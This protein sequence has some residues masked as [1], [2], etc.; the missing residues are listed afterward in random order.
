MRG[1][2]ASL[3]S[4]NLASL[5]GIS[6]RRRRDVFRRVRMKVRTL[7][8]RIAHDRK[9]RQ[10]DRCGVVLAAFKDGTAR[11]RRGIGSADTAIGVCQ[12]TLMR[13]GFGRNA[14]NGNATASSS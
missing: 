5:I 14:A 9:N 11:F 4:I 12:E 3:E 8:L 1:W 7:V 10:V 6:C 2:L 13:F